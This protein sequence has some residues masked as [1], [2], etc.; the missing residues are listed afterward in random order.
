MESKKILV[1]L[2]ATLV[3]AL[4][5]ISNASA[6]VRITSVTLHDVEV[7]SGAANAADISSFAGQV[8]PVKV[9]F[10]A[11]SN[12]SDVRI[13]AWLSGSSGLTASSE[14][15]DLISGK[16]YV[17]FLSLQ[18][19]SNIDLNENIQLV[20]T[21]ESRNDGILGAE[22]IDLTVQRESYVV[23]I[24][25]VNMDTKAVAGDNLALDIVLKNRGM[26]LAEDTFVKAAIPLLGVEEKSYF[27]DLS[28]VDQV[29]PDRA[30]ASERMMYLKIP[31][32]AKPGVYAVEIE[33]Y[34]AD[35]TTTMS[36]KIAIV[37]ASDE[38]TMV[39]PA[40]SKTFAAGGSA[41]YSLIL[42]N[43]GNKVKIYDVAVE[44][45]T[46][47]TVDVDSPVVAIPAGT[48]ATVK[49]KASASKVGVYDF[50]GTVQSSGDLVKRESFVANV[51]GSK[52][53][54]PIAG[55]TTV[56]LTVVLA[57]IFIVLLIVLIVLLTRKPEKTK[58]FGE[59]YY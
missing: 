51:E 7:L 19:P 20:V 43:S 57:I 18:M 47:L 25:D 41:E 35:S 3:L 31:S 21:V 52:V 42:V 9:V 1:S 10:H 55:N 6:D 32:N 27:G 39:S 17:R 33:A 58:E 26:H 11:N 45:P 5:L 12:E 49:L 2:V 23:E 24:L 16:D 50:T 56:L 22:T 48:S 38:S 8:V 30:D 15:F 13:K 59:S 4:F 53:S 46:G 34:N 29:S 37:G 36:K 14:R 28:P 44:A 54:A 40:T